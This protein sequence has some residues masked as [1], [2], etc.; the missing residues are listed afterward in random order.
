ME[1]ILNEELTC[2]FVFFLW[3]FSYLI[4]LIIIIIFY[5]LVSVLLCNFKIS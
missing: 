2:V 4:F 1:N 5:L 3:G